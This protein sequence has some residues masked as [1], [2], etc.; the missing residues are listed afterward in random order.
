MS[1]V[2]HLV[3]EY[4]WTF[5]L[6]LDFGGLFELFFKYKDQ[7]TETM[8]KRNGNLN[9]QILQSRNTIAVFKDLL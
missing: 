7:G 3:P 9:L 8:V 4:S 1:T 2:D 6:S 5:L